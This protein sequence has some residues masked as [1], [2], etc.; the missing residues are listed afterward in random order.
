MKN[1]CLFERF[2]KLGLGLFFLLTAVRFYVERH[3]RFADY[4]IYIRRSPV[5]CFI[6]FFSRPFKQRLSNRGSNGIAADVA[7]SFT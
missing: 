4:R 7:V 6:L 5:D 1:F 2:S 3:Y